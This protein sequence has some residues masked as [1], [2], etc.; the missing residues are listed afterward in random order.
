VVVVLLLPFILIAVAA[1]AAVVFVRR[2]SL[3]ITS[4]GVEIRNYPQ[5][6]MLIP[7]A[8]VRAFEATP[9][10]GNFAGIR[11]ATAVL[12][13]EDET[14]IPVRTLKE[15]DAGAG[16]EALNRRLASMRHDG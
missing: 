1:L 16:I 4:A 13:L 6:P 8:R 9:R 2:S 11:P 3:R 10:G 12:V 5:A 7:L 15:P 14:R